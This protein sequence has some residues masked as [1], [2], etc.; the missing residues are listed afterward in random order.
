MVCGDNVRQAIA[1][2]E[3]QQPAA[4][5]RHK[6]KGVQIRE[7]SPE[8]LATLDETWREVA[9]EL[10]A[11]DEIFKQAYDSLTAWQEEYQTWTEVGYLD[12]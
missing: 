5:V 6:E 7:W 11:R 8:I 3:A 4:L 12:R 10:S 1:E 9:A 2:G